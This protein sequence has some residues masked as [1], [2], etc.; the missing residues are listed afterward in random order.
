MTDLLLFCAE[1]FTH[2]HLYTLNR[3]VVDDLM[4]TMLDALWTRCVGNYT[5]L[6]NEVSSC[7]N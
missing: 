3:Q 7:I 5:R 1:H 4:C 2:E 6:N